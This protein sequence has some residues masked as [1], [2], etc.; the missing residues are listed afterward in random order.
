MQA[1]TVIFSFLLAGVLCSCQR[2]S[3]PTNHEGMFTATFDE[4]VK[5]S[6]SGT[7]I[8]W[9]AGDCINIISATA[10]EKYALVSGA[11]TGSAGFSGNKVTG[12]VFYALYPYDSGAILKEGRIITTFPDRQLAVDNGI[13][14]GSNMAIA[15]TTGNTLQFKNVGGLVKFQITTD[16]V[17]EVIIEGNNGEIV[18]G[19]VSIDWNGGSPT[20]LMGAERF[21]K[22]SVKPSSGN[23]F[24]PGTYH[25]VV[26]PRNYSKGITVT[27]KPAEI[28]LKNVVLSQVLPADMVK[29]GKSAMNLQRSHVMVIDDM[30][31]GR[32]WNYTGM[33]M[34]CIRGKANNV[35]SY[36]DLRTGRTFNPL[37][38]PGQCGADI[39]MCFV[40]SNVPA[41]G[42]ISLTGGNATNFV[43]ETNLNKFP[44][45]TYWPYQERDLVQNWPA[46]GASS[47]RWLSSSEMDE[48]KYDALTHTSDIMHL[49]TEGAMLTSTLKDLGSSGKTTDLNQMTISE[50][51]EAVKKFLL[52]TVK[53]DAAEDYFGVIRFTSY[54]NSIYP[55][56]YFDYK[57][58]RGPNS[59]PITPIPS[60]PEYENDDVPVNEVVGCTT[61]SSQYALTDE[62]ILI[63]GARAVQTLGTKC[64][65]VWFEHA[66]KQYLYNSSWPDNVEN[67]SSLQL[68]QTPYYR[69]LFNMPFKTYS[70]EFNDATVN[71]K[72]GLNNAERTKVYNNLYSLATYLLKTYK[73]TGKT[74]I[75]QNWEGDG[76]LNRSSLSDD[77]L[78]VAIQGMIDWAN[79]RQDAITRA[80][81]DVG[82]D[83]VLVVNAF[84]FNYVLI[85]NMPE[86]FVIDAVVPY[87]HCDLY[88]YSSYS[89]GRSKEVLDEIVK[90]VEHIRSR[91]PAS[92]IYGKH[93]LMIGEFGY[94]ERRVPGKGYKHL[95]PEMDQYQFDMIKGQL[96]RLLDLRLTYIFLWQMYCNGLVDDNGVTIATSPPDPDKM[97]DN[98]HCKGFWLIRADGTKTKTYT[99]LKDD[100]FANNPSVKAKYPVY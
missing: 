12:D 86:P 79:T 63:E 48:E 3:F 61:T 37:N 74:F 32:L 75:I 34:N 62:P 17:G 14:N 84:E 97:A 98:D 9:T 67:L 45:T 95:T 18:A 22:I 99:Y 29:A 21:T 24:A 76:H 69:Q 73:G 33:Q 27:L 51:N 11:G 38:N 43:N 2:E 13:Q 100:L 5:T 42:I 1:K 64:I 93:N 66:G 26:L 44:Q 82:C 16:N 92:S 58:G 15:C 91:T 7:D 89:S 56:V 40:Q 94:D 49:M 31:G 81:K 65:K 59:T 36:I 6:L 71:W 25:A 23:V 52:F 41:L 46:R 57:I 80:R 53:A 83:G 77:K 8:L 28:P 87:T 55:K 47:F 50:L 54:D 35:G 39:Q 72:D 88:S 20:F 90:R 78:P 68:A 10:N 4:Q 85:T 96:D 30:D 19:T 70:L 60:V